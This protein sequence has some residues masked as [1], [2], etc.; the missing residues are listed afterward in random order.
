M[1]VCVC[2]W[3]VCLCLCLCVCVEGVC[4]CVAECVCVCARARALCVCVCVC[5]RARAR[6]ACVCVCVCVC[7]R[8]RVSLILLKMCVCEKLCFFLPKPC[9][10][11]MH[12]YSNVDV[13]TGHYNLSLFLTRLLCLSTIRPS[14]SGTFLQSLPDL[15][16]PLKGHSVSPRSCPPTRSAPSERFGY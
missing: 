3:R 16:T 1:C 2:V 13:L 6:Y 15:I 12:N 4:V 14:L 11:N 10:I 8:A 9:D 7:A 5:V